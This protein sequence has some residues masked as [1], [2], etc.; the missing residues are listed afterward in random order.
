MIQIIKQLVH[1][2][3]S[4]R[5]LGHGFI[6]LTERREAEPLILVQVKQVSGFEK[7][8]L[9]LKN[10]GNELSQEE[11]AMRGDESELSERQ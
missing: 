10:A 6:G 1:R 11:V 8:Q 2:R 3:I 9:V 7:E 4:L 5:E